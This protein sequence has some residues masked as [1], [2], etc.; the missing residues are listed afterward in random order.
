MI[1][2]KPPF[3]NKYIRQIYY[4]TINKQKEDYMTIKDYIWRYDSN[5]FYLMD[6]F[7]INI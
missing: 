1:E 3:L 2:E 5:S 7:K 6:L 4:K